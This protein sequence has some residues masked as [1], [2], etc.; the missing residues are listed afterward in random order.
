MKAFRLNQWLGIV[1]LILCCQIHAQAAER[2]PRKRIGIDMRLV[3]R[4]TDKKP[5]SL[6][7]L[8]EL[9]PQ[10]VGVPLV[11]VHALDWDRFEEFISGQQTRDLRQGE[12]EVRE[13]QHRVSIVNAGNYIRR[14][15]HTLADSAIFEEIFERRRDQRRRRLK[16]ETL[17]NLKAAGPSV[18]DIRSSNE[19]LLKASTIDL[20]DFYNNEY[21]GTLGVGTPRQ[22]MT[23]VF[24]TGSADCWLPAEECA[25]CGHHKKFN[26]ETSSS[27]RAVYASD[28]VGGDSK[29]QQEFRIQY[30]S[31]SVEGKV[32][33]ETLTLGALQLPQYK[34]AEATREDSV[35]A[36]FD[37][38][39]L[40]GLAFPSLSMLN[41]D[42]EPVC[43]LLHKEHPHLEDGFSMYMVRN[44]LDERQ[45]HLT[46]GGFD[47]DL[48]G[49]KALFYYSP[50]MRVSR[51]GG[52][53]VFGFYTVM[54]H[55][56]EVGKTNVYK[57]VDAFY[58]HGENRGDPQSGIQCGV[59][60][61]EDKCHAI[62]DS[63]TSGFGIPSA[64]FSKILGPIIE[65]KVCDLNLLVCLRTSADK[66]PVLMITI[67]PGIK[68]PILPTDYVMC[69]ETDNCYLRLQP[70]DSNS[71]V[72][73]DA[74]IGAYYTYF[75]VGNHRMGF[76]CK[77]PGECSGGDW[78]GLG[79]VVYTNSLPLW[80]RALY[81][82]AFVLCLL[83][84]FSA[85]VGVLYDSV[86]DL[87]DDQFQLKYLFRR[88]TTDDAQNGVKRRNKDGADGALLVNSVRE[89]D[90]L[91]HSTLHTAYGPY[92][93]EERSMLHPPSGAGPRR[94]MV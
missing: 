77:A 69:D 46:F 53:K 84:T 24:D 73:G 55:G 56:V 67:A 6:R 19:T 5:A 43:S 83:T 81:L 21:V 33:I 1:L 10:P 78:N 48:V 45:S 59:C 2:I 29:Q 36:N 91:L 32:M 92:H 85:L 68:L 47:L 27:Y 26:R 49:P 72:L 18:S 35:I 57:G 61:L 80:E 63:G 14:D 65:G 30:G 54:I 3:V 89:T 16:D 90:D 93:A 15:F 38:D 52:D 44:S 20:K 13:E 12:G 39:G 64:Y 25:S 60:S 94:T 76:A 8:Q 9:Y 86:S 40:V 87:L 62:V 88:R 34:V 51:P 66:F 4:G 42:S 74:F 11:D 71:W 70:A 7:I 82:I 79:G 50:M 58:G 23:V 28:G 17:S 22:V 37:M 75:D 31:G 41:Q